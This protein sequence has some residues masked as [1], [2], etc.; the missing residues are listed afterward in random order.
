[1]RQYPNP[2]GLWDG[3]P[4]H[5]RSLIL[6]ILNPNQ[7]HRY[8]L[9]EISRHEWINMYA[10]FSYA[11]LIDVQSEPVD[12]GWQGSRP[13]S[14][15]GSFLV[16]SEPRT[17]PGITRTGRVR[18][19]LLIYTLVELYSLTFCSQPQERIPD[20]HPSYRDIPFSQPNPDFHTLDTS[21][22]SNIQQVK[23]LIPSEFLTRFYSKRSIMETIQTIE[24]VL[25]LFLVHYK[26]GQRRVCLFSCYD[27]QV[28]FRRYFS[29]RRIEESATYM[30]IL[31]SLN[32]H[33]HIA[34]SRFDV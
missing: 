11:G 34:W 26:S 25:G 12:E 24:R 27:T 29:I 8:T 15:H 9:Q 6:S 18:F 3:I 5:L 4:G 28:S 17:S 21:C 10:V 22:Q 7:E 16:Q 2:D 1:M 14:N 20:H 13:K 19:S 30:E 33:K 32:I 23:E 31:L